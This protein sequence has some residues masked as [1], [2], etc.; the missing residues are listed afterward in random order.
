MNLHLADGFGNA[1]GF[2]TLRAAEVA[3]CFAVTPLAPEETKAGANPGGCAQ[4]GSIFALSCGN[5]ARKYTK[6]AVTEQKQ[7]KIIQRLARDEPLHDEQAQ[8]EKI[9][10]T[11]QHIEPIPS[12][13]GTL[14]TDTYASEEVFQIDSSC[15]NLC[16]FSFNRESIVQTTPMPKRI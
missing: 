16:V 5:I 4:K 9:Q 6:Q 12:D 15:G 14:Q 2:S 3:V 8:S 7:A 1:H 10:D 11:S 13:Q